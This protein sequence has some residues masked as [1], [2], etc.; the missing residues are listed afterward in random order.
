[1]LST[2]LYG[3]SDEVHQ[4][5]VPFRTADPLDLLAD[6]LGGALGVLF[7]QALS[8]LTGSRADSLTIDKK[9]TFR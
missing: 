1:V 3:L 7:Y 2:A 9:R 4:Y 6:A 8:R 5:F